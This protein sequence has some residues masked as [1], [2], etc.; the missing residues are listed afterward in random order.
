MDERMRF[1]LEQERGLQTMTELCE[2]YD[3]T[4]ETGYYWLRRYRQGGLEALQDRERAPRQHPNHE[5]RVRARAAA[6]TVAGGE[7]GM[8]RPNTRVTAC[9]R[10]AA[11]RGSS[12]CSVIRPPIHFPVHR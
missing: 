4:R 10:A 7:H 2:M 12:V 8:S 5:T 6:A 11:R 1:V 3:I 9:L